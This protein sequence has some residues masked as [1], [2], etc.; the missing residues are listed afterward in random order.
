MRASTSNA[1]LKTPSDRRDFFWLLNAVH[2]CC[3]AADPDAEQVEPVRKPLG[4]NKVETVEQIARKLHAESLIG[5]LGFKIPDTVILRN[6]KPRKRFSMDAQGRIKVQTLQSSAQLLRVLRRYVHLAQRN[7]PIPS[8]Y[9]SASMGHGGKVL[10]ASRSEPMLSGGKVFP[11]Q[12]GGKAK[13]LH[14]PPRGGEPY[15]EAAVLYYD[16]G[17]VRYMTTAEALKQMENVSRLPKEFWQHIVMLQMPV[18]VQ[19]STRSEATR[20]VT[21]SFDAGSD[22]FEPQAPLPLVHRRSNSINQIDH[23]RGQEGIAVATVPRK[24]NAGF[25]AKNGRYANSGASL[26]SGRLE[27]VLDEGDGTLWLINA[28]KL[29]VEHKEEVAVDTNPEE[30]DYIKYFKEDEFREHMQEQEQKYEGLKQRWELQDQ[31]LALNYDDKEQPEFTLVSKNAADRLSGVKSPD[32][33][34]KYYQAESQMLRHYFDIM[35]VPVDSDNAGKVAVDSSKALDWA[36]SHR[37]KLHHSSS[38]A[39]RSARQEP[40]SRRSSRQRVQSAGNIR[41]SR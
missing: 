26:A 8:A 2:E 34:L 30:D 1:A 7:R 37:G 19:Q 27:F 21:Y 5:K 22:G 35:A 10:Q 33:L 23:G 32:E 36:R 20:Y 14:S 11:G 24:I 28:D 25:S 12:V 3:P 38:N 29:V 9:N 15:R 18:P 16:D 17:A 41:Q 13:R 31:P 39:S 4:N 6:G 40:P